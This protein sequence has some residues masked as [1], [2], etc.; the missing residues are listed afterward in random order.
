MCWRRWEPVTAS[1]RYGKSYESWEWSGAAADHA[2][3]FLV[4]KDAQPSRLDVAWDFA[5]AEGLMSGQVVKPLAAFA[6]KRGIKPG[7]SG[8]GGVYTRYLGSPSSDRR[9]RIYRKDLQDPATL[10]DLGP[11]MRVELV[12][13]GARAR[14]LWSVVADR[15][16]F[17]AAAA[18]HVLQMTGRAVQGDVAPPP[19]VEVTA[20]ADLAQMVLAFVKQHGFTLKVMQMFGVNLDGLCRAYYGK[21]SRMTWHRHHEKMRRLGGVDV[22]RAEVLVRRAI[23]GK[24]AERG[25]VTDVV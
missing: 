8:H 4:G 20:D 16:A 25:R 6:R 14:A 12:V 3:A 9:L 19:L 24:G 15:E 2:A 18:G 21:A 23:A 1:K 5:V 10:L 11:V 17:Y 22:K 7:S 13:K